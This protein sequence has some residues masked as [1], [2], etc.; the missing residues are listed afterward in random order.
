MI[1]LNFNAPAI[2]QEI[3]FLKYFK[4][5]VYCSFAVRPRSSQIALVT[6][7]V[8]GMKFFDY[9]RIFLDHIISF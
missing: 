4:T 2:F 1:S 3:R 6:Q 9:I 7:Y 8:Y 5:A